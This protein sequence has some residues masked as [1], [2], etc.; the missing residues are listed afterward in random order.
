MARILVVDDD[1]VMCLLLKAMCETMGH[2]TSVTGTMKAGLKEAADGEY[3]LILLDVHLPDGSG[4]ESMRSFRNVKSLP[5][6]IIITGDGDPN[7][8]ELAIR[9]GA[10][11][12]IHKPAQM[13][14]LS[15][16]V[17]RAL[18]YRESNQDSRPALY[19]KR[20]ELV[21][22]SPRIQQC[23]EL[24]GK[25]A[26][27]RANV[28]ITGETGV[29]KE[30]I[31]SLIHKNS[32]RAH[33]DFLVVDCANLPENLVESMLFGHEKGAFTGADQAK[34]GLVKQADGGT[35]FLDE[36]GELPLPL[37]K[38][39]LRVLQE[40]RF[41]PVGSLKEVTSDFYLISASNR[42]LEQMVQEG[43]FR[44]DLFFRLR[45]IQID[46]PPLR[47]R[48]EDFVPLMSHFVNGYQEK[49]GLGVKGI[50]PDLFQAVRSYC[51]PGN[52]RELKNAL[53][54]AYISS[55]KQPVLYPNHLPPEIRIHL[56]RELLKL[57]DPTDDSLASLKI[58]LKLNEARKLME[59]LYLRDLLQAAQG[60]IKE[61]SHISGLA[62]SHL[63]NLCREH[64]IALRQKGKSWVKD[65]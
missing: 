55:G 53:E 35:L 15:L 64:G 3:D 40:R 10:W 37:Q 16:A 43:K 59:K 27:G 63:Y 49:Y 20:A 26:A 39:F 61:A 38:N 62:A 22:E 24:V 29:G 46:V 33:R 42:N 31:A 21:G 19:L 9:S 18:Q 48:P 52:V 58:P 25:A 23:L 56:K 12:Y 17:S 34:T 6:I 2:L 51:W 32:A 50:S 28:L 54:S 14:D 57:P 45:T 65:V 13:D 47:E 8:A 36:V 30:V 7:G 44:E 60:N 41:R 1:E 11:D 5:E 4:L